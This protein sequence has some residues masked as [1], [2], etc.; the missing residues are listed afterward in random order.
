MIRRQLADPA[1]ISDGI[2]PTPA[3]EKPTRRLLE[4][5]CTDEEQAGWD[6]LDSKGDDPLLV[7]GSQSF[8]DAVLLGLASEGDI[9]SMAY[10]DPEAHQT[11]NLPAQL[12]HS[13]QSSSNRG[14]S[15]LGNVDGSDI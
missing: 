6:Q 1:E 4:E 11:T 13:N 9:K 2:F 15:H 7:A 14:W 12:V 5:D 8:T 3:G 10:I